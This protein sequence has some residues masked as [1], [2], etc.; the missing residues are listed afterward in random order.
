[1]ELQ[2]EQSQSFTEK[3]EKLEKDSIKNGK[4]ERVS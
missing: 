2:D 1:M 4:D 3:Q